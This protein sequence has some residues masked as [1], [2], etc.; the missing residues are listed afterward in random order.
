VTID[1]IPNREFTAHVRRIN[2]NVDSMSGTVKVVLDFDAD[3]RNYLTESAFARVKL[4]MET[5]KNAI[6]VPK[7]AVISE[8]ARSYLMVVKEQAAEGES[9]G[10]PVHVAERIEIQTGLEDSNKLEVLSG[11]DDTSQI[12]TLGQHSL[13]S[14][15]MVVVTNA[16]AQLNEKAAIDPKQLL[17]DAEKKGLEASKAGAGHADHVPH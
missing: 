15:S 3:G 16:T 8:N 5:H 17:T 6:L 1:S 13:K 11:V 14:G 12:I 4:I 9:D 10:K 7:D 2:P